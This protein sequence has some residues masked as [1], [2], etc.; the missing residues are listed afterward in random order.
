MDSVELQLNDASDRI[1]IRSGYVDKERIKGIPGARWNARDSVWQVP[2]SVPSATILQAEFGPRIVADAQLVTA[3]GVLTS[4]RS[5]ALSLA[6]NPMALDYVPTAPADERLRPY[7][8]LGVDWLLTAET[9]LLGDEM[10]AGKTAQ[11]VSALE[12][13]PE[14]G[15][16]LIVCPKSV[17]W[18][19]QREIAT[20]SESIVPVVAS[21]SV[22]KR[23]KA[24]KAVAD[25]DAN[26]LLIG[27]EALRSH[28]RVAPYGSIRL[29]RCE[30]CGGL[31]GE[32]TETRCETHLKEANEIPWAAVILDEAH[33]AKDAQ[34]LQTRAA[35]WVAHQPSVRYRWALTGTPVANEVTDL[36]SILHLIDPVAWPAKTTFLDRWVNMVPDP[37]G[38]MQVLGI[39]PERF[40]EFHALVD[41][42][43]L[44]RTKAM[45][46]PDLPP[47]V[48]VT[49]TCELTP[50]ER[51]AYVEMRD[52]LITILEDGS[53]LMAVNPMVQVGRLLQLANSTM[54]AD[55]ISGAAT[56]VDPSTK[57]G[58]LEETLDEISETESVVVWFAHRKLLHLAEARLEKAGKHFV[59]FH[60]E[61]A[62]HDR[63]LA[64]QS[65]Q[66]GN[67]RLM[68]LT[69]GA[70][71]EGITLTRAS[72]QVYVQRTWSLID[73]LQSQDR[74][75][76]PGQ[77]ADKVTII[78]LIAEDTVEERLQEVLDGKAE[79]L[80]AVV[81]DREALL[82]IL[83]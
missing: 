13:A 44:R 47:K 38:G 37:W 64:E 11:V 39:K 66:A 26:T 55:P 10:G 30:A 27:Y 1:V 77:L 2:L 24:F 21:G 69:I 54:I 41:P 33:R 31:P 15:P 42:Y 72:T 71:K 36:W 19:W 82:R 20:W 53:D 83:R 62:D 65:F 67:V 40:D 23:R 74:L 7:Q 12:A 43:I 70:G 60:G 61:M 78:D 49:R 80:E 5:E 29:K 57:L 58:L 56:P 22:A 35:W 3:L 6:R 73:D 50:K 16:F 79:G 14:K 28:T 9:G 4:K 51:K 17:L 81:Q 76:R 25:G 52:E 45:V 59:S 48:R 8:R 63:A 75:H 46:L 68:L 18:T 32:V 34:A